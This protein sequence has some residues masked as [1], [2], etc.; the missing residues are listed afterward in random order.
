MAKFDV[1]IEALSPIH[2]GSGNADVNLDAEIVHD[3][4]G[5]PYFPAKRFKGLLYES[6]VEIDEM[7]TLA[8]I[9]HDELLVE[10]I[11]H[12]RSSSAVQLIV[13][14]F[15]LAPHDEY[16]KIRA[17][18]LYMF[19][20]YGELFSPSD[21]LSAFTSTR[22]QTQLTDGVVAHGSLRN[23]RVLDAGIKFFGR[24]ELK[25][26]DERHVQ[27]IA[28]SIRNLKSAGLKRSRG[29]GRLECTMKCGDETDQSLLEKFFRSGALA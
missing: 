4:F 17:E 5:L 28:L 7:L 19:G 25:N 22:Y 1:T 16:Q 24:L 29:F 20:E 6:A 14:N 15:Y 21:V 3:E 13:P 2:L 23:M 10:E 8:E 26:G 12:R 11:F 27:L 9:D 18:C